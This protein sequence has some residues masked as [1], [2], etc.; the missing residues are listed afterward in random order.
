MEE[1]QLAGARRLSRDELRT[2]LERAREHIA[3]LEADRWQS[4]ERLIDSFAQHLQDGFSLLSPAG[5]HLDVN[6]AFCAMVG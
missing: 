4:H 3:D 6:P 1:H 5:V 2:E